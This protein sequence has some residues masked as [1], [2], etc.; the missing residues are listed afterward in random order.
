MTN[1]AQEKEKNQAVL[2]HA[3][4]DSYRS[5]EGVVVRAARLGSCSPTC[6]FLFS[7]AFFI[8]ND[9]NVYH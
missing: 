4:V 1:S 3:G 8:A 6:Y 7:S 5:E 2:K 9:D